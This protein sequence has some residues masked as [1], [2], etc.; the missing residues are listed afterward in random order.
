MCV[1]SLHIPYVICFYFIR[2]HSTPRFPSFEQKG[3]RYKGNFSDLLFASLDEK[4]LPNR[5]CFL[6]T[7]TEHKVFNSMRIP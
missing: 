3:L 7:D 5:S 4:D 1:I 2:L 6:R